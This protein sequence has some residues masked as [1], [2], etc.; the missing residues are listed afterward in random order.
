MSTPERSYAAAA[1]GSLNASVIDA[2]HPYYLH[3]SDN[4]GMLLTTVMLNK[5]NYSQWNQSMIIALSSK[6]KLGFVDGSCNKPA[7]TFLLSALWMRCNHMTLSDEL[8]SLSARPRCTYTHCTC[9][10][11]TKSDQY[12]CTI[13]LT[14]FLMGLSEQF[15]SVRGQILLMKPVPTLSQCYSILLQEETQ[16]D[17]QHSSYMTGHSLAINV[18]N[19]YSGSQR[20]FGSNGS[21]PSGMSKKTTSDAL[22]C[23]ICHLKGHIRDTCFCLHG[24]PQWHRLF[25]KPKPKP[26]AKANNVSSTPQLAADIG[27]SG[28]PTDTGESKGTDLYDDQYQNLL[29][30][31]QATMKTHDASYSGTPSA[32]TVQFAGTFQFLSC[33]AQISA[34]ISSDRWILDSGATD[35]ITYYVDKLHNVHSCSSHLQL[36]NG[37][38]VSVT[39]IRDFHLTPDIILSSV[40]YVLS[41]TYNLLSIPKLTTSSKASVVFTSHVCLLQD[42]TW[43]RAVEI[44]KFQNGLYLFQPSTSQIS[45]CNSV[46]KS[47]VDMWHARLG[48]VPLA[49]LKLLPV[50]CN[51]TD[52][53]IC[54][55]CHL[56]KQP[57]LPFLNST[58]SSSSLFELV[59]VDLWG[60]YHCKTQGNCNMFL[61]VLDDKSK[62]TWVFLLSD[63]SQVSTILAQFFA[64]V[65]NHFHTSVKILRSDNG[66]EFINRSLE[67]CLATLG[68]IHQTSCTYTPQQNGKVERKHRQLLNTARAL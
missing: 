28:N 5:Q 67:T 64:Y 50:S 24:Y 49:M 57:R 32:N 3:P 26:R 59:H 19:S 22:V 37:H 43:K 66:S 55:S 10:V 18:K 13:Q 63:K 54:D 4:P 62:T 47:S 58:S 61:T 7:L 9:N 16:R 2:N 46:S 14:Q 11:N 51:M 15:T 39:H 40:L 33:N 35:H 27:S 68:I 23:D 29:K 44:G 1:S 31:I 20:K 42:P 34:S 38:T 53:S 65:Q 8:D 45:T 41:F 21:A 12:E 48:H 6:L 25:G 36:P 60:P 56:A 17:V 52:L 30:I